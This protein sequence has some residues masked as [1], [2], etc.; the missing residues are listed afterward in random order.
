MDETV[1]LVVRHL[2]ERMH[3][4]GPRSALN[5][6][7]AGPRIRGPSGRYARGLV[8]GPRMAGDSGPEWAVEWLQELGGGS[9]LYPPVSEIP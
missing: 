2:H 9:R 3:A 6:T 7:R 4:R 1:D 8:P 5:V